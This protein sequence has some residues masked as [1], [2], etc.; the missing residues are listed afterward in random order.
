MEGP[1]VRRKAVFI[2]F[3][4]FIG[5]SSSWAQLPQKVPVLVITMDTTRAD[6]LGCYGSNEGLTPSLDALAKKSVIFDHCETAIPLTVPSHTTIFSGLDPIDTG[7]RKNLENRIPASVPL[8]QEEM[9]KAGY[10]T[11]AFVSSFVLLGRWGMERGFSKYDDAFYSPSHPD[12]NERTAGKTLAAALP[13]VL[14]QK[15]PWYCW[16]HLYDPHY[17]YV[18][19]EP[20]LSKYK[21]QPYDG[22]IAYMDACLGAFFDKLRAAGI[23]DKALVVVCSDHGESLGEHGEATHG[24]FLYDAST[25]VAFMIHLPGETDQRRVPADVG[26]VDVAP[27]IRALAGLPLQKSDGVSLVPFINGRPESRGPVYMEC[28][29]ALDNYGWAPLYASVENRSKY[30]LAPKP[31]F[32]SLEKDP[33]ELSNLAGKEGVAAKPLQ[34]WL[35]GRISQR[36]GKAPAEKLSLDKEELRSLTSLGYISGAP[37]SKAGSYRDPK[38]MVSLLPDIEKA[39]ILLQN[40]D[41]REAVSLLEKVIPKDP[42]NPLFHYQLGTCYLQSDKARAESELKKALELKPDFPQAC[43]QLLLLWITTGRAEAALD[44]GK[45]VLKQT[46]DY[47]GAIHALTGFAAIRAG[48]PAAEARAF[49]DGGIRDGVEAPIALKGRA[50]LAVQEG[51]NDEAIAYLKKLAAVSEPGYMVNVGRDPR[52]APL[53]EDA[54]F[55]KIILTAQNSAR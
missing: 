54:R 13:W 23:L 11:G 52:F 31:E 28:L 19:P 46:D 48:R 16:V 34:S 40:G 55:W 24:I 49:L 4:I 32:Y 42:G 9:K 53:R 35:Q 33:K 17:P 14:A 20:Y 38:D 5:A 29:A 10:A 39:E 47:D 25:R 15:G 1:P 21:A 36:E 44:L 30:I 2:L 7:V 27:T 18:P 51:K 50:I 3:S 41:L 6:K 45:S 43:E 26:L 37:G 12:E 8:L 22:E